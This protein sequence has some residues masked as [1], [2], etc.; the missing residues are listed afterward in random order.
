[1]KQ[2]IRIILVIVLFSIF[3][4][5][6]SFAAENTWHVTFNGE[7]LSS[8]FT[9]SSLANIVENMQPGDSE[10]MSFVLKNSSGASSRWYMENKTL[11]S[12]EDG[13]AASGG[14]YTYILK[15][16]NAKGEETTIYSSDKVGGEGSSG[17]LAGLH[18]AT[19]ALED[20]FYLDTLE[21]QKSGILTLYVELDGESQGNVY[22]SGDARLQVLFAVDKTTGADSKGPV[23]KTGDD[24][25]LRPAYIAMLI[26]GLLLL[27]LVLDAYTDSVYPIRLRRFD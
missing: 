21:A 18:E 2:N 27:A 13:T 15:Y 3:S 10:T 12:L 16:K 23:V 8:D 5:A 14:A 26:S 24:T 19:N 20:M 11:Q 17:A 6:A 22:Q 25:N 1:M 9:S 7:Q 4:T